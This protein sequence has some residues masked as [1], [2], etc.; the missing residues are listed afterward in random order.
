MSGSLVQCFLPIRN[1]EG[2]LG[3]WFEKNISELDSIGAELIIVD[4]GSSDNSVKIV[5]SWQYRK[6][7]II[8]ND[9]DLG[10]ENSFR[11]AKSLMSSKYRFF[12]PADDWLAPGYLTEAVEVMEKESHVDVVYGKSYLFNQVSGELSVRPS[13]YRRVGLNKE[14]AFFAMFFNNAVPDISLYRSSTLNCDEGSADW[15]LPGGPAS[16][17]INGLSFYTGNGQCYS[18]KGEHQLS[19]A[20]A[21]SGK[22]YSFLMG[23][24]G[25]LLMQ[26]KESIAN[27]ILWA[28]FISYFHAG[29]S[30]LES[31]REME[32]TNNYAKHALDLHKLEVYSNAALLLVDDLLVDPNKAEFRDVGRLGTLDDFIY[33][34]KLLGANRPVFFSKEL[35]RRGLK[36]S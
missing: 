2:F 22:Y 13:P 36:I 10:L 34:V 32:K 18:G 23:L 27:Q 25:E 3:N 12:L 14:N 7:R 35:E 19:K 5:E 9:V 4:N 20:W 28:A 30:L 8:K 31:I 21:R 26:M 15:F 1:A 29:K 17:L 24:Y 11:V 6:C 16:V 33:F